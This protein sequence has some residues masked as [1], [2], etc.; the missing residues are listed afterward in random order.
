MGAAS[1]GAVGMFAILISTVVLREYFTWDH[2]VGSE[3]AR[4]DA[5]GYPVGFALLVVD[6]DN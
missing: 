6:A 2:G 3:A 1:G 4:R 5:P